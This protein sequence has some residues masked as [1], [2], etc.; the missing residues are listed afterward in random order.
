MY[1]KN[2]TNPFFTALLLCLVFIFAACSPSVDTSDP[3]KVAFAFWTAVHNQELE[4]ATDLI[5]PS[6]REHLSK[7]M[8]RDFLMHTVPDL[9]DTLKFEMR[10]EGDTAVAKILDSNGI[11]CDLIKEN[12]RWWVR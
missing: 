7:M 1:K 6:Q 5:H 8:Q 4:A 12:G 10:V 3:E 2:Q 11:A 9:P